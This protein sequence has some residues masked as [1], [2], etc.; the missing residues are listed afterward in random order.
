MQL[1]FKHPR[2]ASDIIVSRAGIFLCFQYL[3]FF[4]FAK[5]ITSL[6]GEDE[7]EKYRGR[8]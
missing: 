3:D 5:N 6:W 4:Y 2:I 7:M 8:K 1:S